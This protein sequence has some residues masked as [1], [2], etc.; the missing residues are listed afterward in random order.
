MRKRDKTI[1]TGTAA[2]LAVAGAGAALA[3]TDALSP[4][5]RSQAVID[6]AAKQLG[7]ESSELSAALKQALENRID[8]AVDAGTLTEEQ[9]SALKERLESAGVP[10]VFGSFGPSFG[11]RFEHGF[12]LGSFGK[13]EAA[14]TYLGLTEDALHDALHDGTSLAD[15]AKAEGKSVAG[16]VDALVAEAGERID[17]AVAEGRLSE[18]RAAELKGDLEERTTDLVNREPGSRDRFG[19]RRF[20]PGFGPGFG[21]FH[22]DP[23]RFGARVRRNRTA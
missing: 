9:G 18:E 2:V 23:R 15:I 5:E 10:L 19:D 13:L 8:E 4:E 16:L 20:R 12:G 6:D 11:D 7:I 14:A 21:P 1:I 22:G 3:A 17:S